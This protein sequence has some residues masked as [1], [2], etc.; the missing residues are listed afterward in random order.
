MKTS[1]K[2]SLDV[3]DEN[4]LYVELSKDQSSQIVIHYKTF[5]KGQEHEGRIAPTVFKTEE[6]GENFKQLVKDE[7][8]LEACYSLRNEVLVITSASD[9]ARSAL[10][11]GTELEQ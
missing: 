4:K 6:A 1:Q 11:V 10:A 9:H 5:F 3:S 7:G 8:Y 2:S